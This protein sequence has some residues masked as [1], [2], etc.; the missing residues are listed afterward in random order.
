MMNIKIE[1]AELGHFGKEIQTQLVL[2]LE[3]M[4]IKIQQI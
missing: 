3:V 1:E 4:S 2:A